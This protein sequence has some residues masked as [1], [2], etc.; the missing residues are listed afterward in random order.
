MTS[1]SANKSAIRMV[2]CMPSLNW[3]RRIGGTWPAA[4]LVAGIQSHDPAFQWSGYPSRRCQATDWRIHHSPRSDCKVLSSEAFASIARLQPDGL[5]ALS[6]T[7]GRED[8]HVRFANDAATVCF[9]VVQR[10][11]DAATKLSGPVAASAICCL[12]ASPPISMWRHRLVQN[13]CVSCLAP[14]ARWP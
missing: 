1:V 4:Y 5:R 10:L 3:A 12:I 13:R 6:L 9:E 7:R 8:S 11:R 14:S 2:N